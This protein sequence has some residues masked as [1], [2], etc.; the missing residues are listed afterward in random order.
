MFSSKAKARAWID[1]NQLLQEIA[2]EEDGTIDTLFDQGLLN[3][4]AVTLI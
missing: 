1:G 4:A 3:I 2:A